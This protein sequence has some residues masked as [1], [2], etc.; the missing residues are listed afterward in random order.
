MRGKMIKISSIPG[1][2]VTDFVPVGVNRVVAISGDGR[3]SYFEFMP[4][5]FLYGQ[6]AVSKDKLFDLDEEEICNCMNVCSKGHYMV[7]CTLRR[8]GSSDNIQHLL[9][10]IFLLKIVDPTIIKMRKTASNPGS[11][12]KQ[13][14]NRK[15]KISFKILDTLDFRKSKFSNFDG[16][17]I[18]NVNM[19]LYKGI[20]PLILA[21]QHGAENMMFS[22][23]IDPETD[24]FKPFKN[25]LSIHK[26][27]TMG[28]RSGL[29]GS[30]LTS[31]DDEGNITR[32]K[33]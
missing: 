3:I 22:F 15:P 30:M 1:D 29:L 20:S 21:C 27:Y 19:Q 32:I 2:E 31:I 24:K 33:F 7:V 6:I 16:S 12:K 4:K 8:T 5:T 25:P 13:F 11:G 28:W 26:G 23:T 14:F 10:R 17:F 9:S 18:S